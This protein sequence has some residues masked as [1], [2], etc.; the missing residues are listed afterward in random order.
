MEKKIIYI[1]KR[2]PNTNIPKD[3]YVGTISSI[4]STL[5]K[6]GNVKTG[7]TFEEEKKL[8]P[9]ILGCQYDSLDY[10]KKLKEFFAELKIKVPFGEEVSLDISSDAEGN[11]A[12]PLDYIKYKFALANSEVAHS[13]ELCNGT[14]RYYIHDP[15]LKLEQDY[16]K[17]SVKKDAYKEFIKISSDTKKV[18]MLLSVLGLDFK[19]LGDKERELKLEDYVTNIDPQNFLLVIKDK[20]LET[21]AFIEE[22]VSAQ[23]LSKVGNSY[24]DGEE[25]IGGSLQEAVL[26]LNDKK[27]SGDLVKLKARL[28]SFKP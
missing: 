24:L 5:D 7:L 17:L 2:Q 13:K 22:L 16:N 1:K 26:Y 23:I 18:T 28:E 6:S 15:Q 25:V 19:K 9:R 21:K 11:Y 12:K 10:N 3:V 27:N 8:M 14:K 20:D 4:G